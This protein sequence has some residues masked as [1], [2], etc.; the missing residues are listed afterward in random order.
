MKLKV[1]TLLKGVIWESLGVIILFVYALFTTGDIGTAGMIG[2]GY[3]AFR[4]IL[5]YPFDRLYK[6]IRRGRSLKKKTCDDAIAD[7]IVNDW[8]RKSQSQRKT[9][10]RIDL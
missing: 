4:V 7:P 1:H 2:F 3:P 5:W 9:K 6:R 10:E 8:F